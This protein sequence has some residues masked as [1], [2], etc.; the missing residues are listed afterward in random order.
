MMCC[1]SQALDKM[2][3]FIEFAQTEQGPRLDEAESSVQ[4]VSDDYTFLL[5]RLAAA[6][7]P[8]KEEVKK[9][10]AAVTSNSSEIPALRNEL[11]A[12]TAH[13]R[14]RLRRVQDKHD[15]DTTSMEGSFL[16]VS[17]NDSRA[18][19]TSAQSKQQDRGVLSRYQILS[20]L[21]SKAMQKFRSL[22]VVASTARSRTGES[23]EIVEDGTVEHNRDLPARAAEDATVE[24]NSHGTDPSKQDKENEV[25]CVLDGPGSCPSCRENLLPK[26][27]ETLG[28]IGEIE[29]KLETARQ[30]HDFHFAGIKRASVDFARVYVKSMFGMGCES[31]SQQ[32]VFLSIIVLAVAENRFKKQEVA[33][34]QLTQHVEQLQKVF[35]QLIARLQAEMVR[36]LPV[37]CS[38]GRLC[39]VT[40]F[41]SCIAVIDSCRRS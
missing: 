3:K 13:R 12:S 4:A 15:S 24:S 10:T 39:R 26:L 7:N 11:R 35:K 1:I 18:P 41:V 32:H 37:P 14:R 34:Q 25:V 23:N 30:N 2:D 9:E 17:S 8:P 22:P 5:N 28:R 33:G 16:F 38:T 27:D 31:N 40:L 20:N 21:H 6:Y 36:S 29:Q 19:S